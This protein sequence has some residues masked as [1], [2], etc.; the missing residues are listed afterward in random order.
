MWGLLAFALTFG[1]LLVTALFMAVVAGMAL[2]L[3]LVLVVAAPLL[4]GWLW[5]FCREL[6]RE[7]HTLA[8]A[9]KSRR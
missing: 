9:W 8:A 1:A 7:R 6:W 3:A 4:L 5:G 2:W